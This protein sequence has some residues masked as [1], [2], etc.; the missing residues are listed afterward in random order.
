MVDINVGR[1]ARWLRAMGYDA[2]LF[3]GRD[4]SDMVRTALKE[5]RIVLTRDGGVARRRVAT[6]GRLRVLLL[7]S[8]SVREQLRQVVSAFSLN[9][10][11]RPFSL[12]LECNR[13]LE[14]HGKEEVVGLVPPYVLSIQWEFSRCPS[15]ERIFWQGTHWDAMR[16]RLREL[17]AV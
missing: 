15:C 9:P 16:S 10:T 5:E 3:T 6:T 14:G 7:R 13:P 17:E 8:D 2:V 11:Y 1:L 4:D 12:C